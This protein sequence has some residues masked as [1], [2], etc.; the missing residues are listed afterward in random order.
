MD[1]ASKDT[2]G[3][4]LSK[5]ERERARSAL[6]SWQ[7]PL[8]MEREVEN[9]TDI[10]EENF[11]IQG[12]LEFLRDAYTAAMFAKLR[13]LKR[14]RLCAED[15]PDFEVENDDGS[16]MLFEVTEVDLPGR[17]RG[18][19]YRHHIKQPRSTRLIDQ[20]EMQDNAAAIPSALK[21]ISDRKAG[22]GYDPSW[23]LVVLLNIP[24]YGVAV[25]ETEAAMAAA[26]EAS[27][28]VFKEVWIVWRD[29]LYCPWPNG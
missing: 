27:G 13:G 8:Q 15:R 9:C 16:N 10:L 21:S 5:A 28:A 24:T 18:D 26:T 25:A 2:S 1:E 19:E 4:Y 3:R 6:Q 11:F 22:G 12:G 7:S 14:V 20:R 17:R 29:K 23:G